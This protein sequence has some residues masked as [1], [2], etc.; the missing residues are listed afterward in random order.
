M[1][2]DERKRFDS[3]CKCVIEM[4]RADRDYGCGFY[5]QKKW[6]S[7]YNATWRIARA[8]MS[9]REMMVELA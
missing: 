7:L 6:L 9:R 8:E 4:H 5:N 2:T 1:T 3:L